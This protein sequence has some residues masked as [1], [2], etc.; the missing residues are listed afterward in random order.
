MK[1]G[2]MSQLYKGISKTGSRQLI[3]FF[4][5]LKFMTLPNDSLDEESVED[6]DQTIAV[7]ES[8]QAH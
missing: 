5:P 1:T 8:A 3:C 6:V 4:G 2:K 7:P